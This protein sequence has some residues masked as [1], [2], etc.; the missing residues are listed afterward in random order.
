MT[1][2]EALHAYVEV[3]SDREAAA[4]AEARQLVAT[5]EESGR[6]TLSELANMPVAEREELMKGMHFEVDVDELAE[7]EEATGADGLDDDE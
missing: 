6:I 1:T 4:L 7:W 5:R 3:L 2:K